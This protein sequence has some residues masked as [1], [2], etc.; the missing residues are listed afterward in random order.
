MHKMWLVSLSSALV[1]G[2]AGAGV[3]ARLLRQ[4][5]EPIG[6]RIGRDGA[7]EVTARSPVD[8]TLVERI[9]T[10]EQSLRAVRRSPV[11]GSRA[12]QA[13]ASASASPAVPAAPTAVSGAVAPLVAD[14]MF[15]AAV[16]DIVDR[17]EEDRDSDRDVRRAERAREQAEHWA[18][19]LTTRLELTSEQAARVLE[20]R[21]QLASDLRD[22]RR[23]V[24]G[25]PFVPR[26]QRR[27]AVAALRERAE[28]ELR[29]ELA[30][31]QLARYEK[32]DTG[33]KLVR[34]PDSD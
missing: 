26:E 8:A 7:D 5:P 21:T 4:Q 34:P 18:R 2:L 17:A 23:A 24:E 20:I 32:L 16:L 15:E 3:A 10:L 11:A 6:A 30:P 29:K 12:A 31:E 14:P 1:G 19:E 13:A 25:G 28:H 9:E 33:L 27:A 22:H